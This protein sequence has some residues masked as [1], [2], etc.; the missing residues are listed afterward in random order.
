MRRNLALCCALVAAGCSIGGTSDPEHF[1]GAGT[2]CGTYRVTNDPSS[3]S[4][5]DLAAQQC[6]VDAFSAGDTAYL[7][8]IAD[9]TEGHPFR[10]G[11]QVEERNSVTI[12]TD[13][14]DDPLGPDG[15]QRTRCQVLRVGDG[16]VPEYETCGL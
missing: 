8:V 7:S 13:W 6:L 12:E 9:T 11:F 15:I 3:V 5:E 4:Q 16:G 1:E 14:N 10:I 2:Q